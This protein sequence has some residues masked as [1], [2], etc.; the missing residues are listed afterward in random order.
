MLNMHLYTL[1]LTLFLTWLRPSPRNVPRLMELVTVSADVAR[2]DA[3]DEEATQ[4]ASIAVHESGVRPRAVGPAGE[5]GAFQVFPDARGLRDASAHEALR[6]L[7]SQGL[8]G[9]AG[10][11]AKACPKLTSAL[12]KCA[13]G[14]C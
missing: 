14:G 3:T 1:V 4:L 7:R 5:R 8:T 9:Y 12:M 2:T 11:G 13:E 6:R 10:C